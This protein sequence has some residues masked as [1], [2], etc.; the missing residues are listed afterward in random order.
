MNNYTTALSVMTAL[1]LSMPMVCQAQDPLSTLTKVKALTKQGKTEDAVKLCDAVIKRYSGN[2]NTA[3]QFAYVLPFY[4]WEKGVCYFKGGMYDEA[5]NA[6]KAFMEEPKWK[7]PATLARAKENIP[8]QP[9]AYEPFFTYALFQMGNCRYKQGV[10]DTGKN[11]GD[12]SKFED[13][14]TCFEKYLKLVQSGKVSSMEKKLKM[15]GQ[16]CFILVQANILKEKPDFKALRRV[17]IALRRLPFCRRSNRKR[18]RRCRL[19]FEV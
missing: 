8:G 10:G 5:Y 6:F 18:Y 17:R 4:A 2:G 12:K 16:I 7:D 11:N 3:K 9:E 15:D 1:A 14:I 19:V 13:A